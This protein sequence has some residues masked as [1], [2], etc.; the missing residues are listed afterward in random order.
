MKKTLLALSGLIVPMAMIAQNGIEPIDASGLYLI[1]ISPN[2]QY[3]GNMSGDAGIYSLETR[4]LTS[5]SE[6]ALGLGNTIA[7]NGV[8]VGE[9]NDS[10]VIMKDGEMV[11]PANYLDYW[12][13]DFNAINSDAS[14]VVGLINNSKGAVMYVPFIAD[15]DASGNLS[16]PTILPYPDVDLFGAAPQFV[17]AVWV[18]DDGKT[19]AGQVCDNIGYYV[20]PIIYQQDEAGEWSYYLPSEPLFNPDKI[21]IPANPWSTEPAWPDPTQFMSGALKQAYEEAYEAYINGTGAAPEPEQYMTDSEYDAYAEAVETYN[22][23]FYSQQ[24][25][26]NAFFAAYNKV[27]ATSPTFSLN[28]MA[29]QASGELMC[30]HGGVINDDNQMEGKLFCFTPADKGIKIMEG[31][32]PVA[33]PRQILPDGTLVVSRPLMAGPNT[34]FLMPGSEEFI[35]VQEYLEPNYP[36]LA[37][38]IDQ[39]YPGG[40]GLV[41]VSDDF[42]VISGGV[43]VT[44]LAEYDEDADLPYYYYSYILAG[45]QPAG[46]ESIVA[47]NTDGLYRVYNLKGVKV[48]E[49]KDGS[50]L[51]SLAKGIYIVNGKKV[52]VK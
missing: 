5:Y 39:R 41:S 43:F 21:E 12:F 38:Y 19:V 34:W 44:E 18:S 14:K 2:G 49:T 22:D 42:S 9:V 36:E 3:I 10:P 17:T 46:V 8:A 32:D 11:R 23:W 33:V 30:Q 31:P 40:N 6:A 48:L 45:L 52:L 15:M 37:E 51:N 27:I 26:I 16:D 1:K 28:D 50:Q 13:C 29:L 25:N 4:E 20:Y 47:E 7:N 35:T 24:A